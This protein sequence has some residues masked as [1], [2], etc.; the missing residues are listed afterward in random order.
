MIRAMAKPKP[1]QSLSPAQ[2]GKARVLLNNAVKFMQAGMG[3]QARAHC[4]QVLAFAPDHAQAHYLLGL[5]AIRAGRFEEARG[6]IDRSL[7]LE[8]AHPAG[9]NN[10]GVVLKKLGLP[11]EALAHFEAAAAQ[12]PDY[13]EAH[14]NHGNTSME[15]GDAAAAVASFGRAIAARPGYAEAF[16]NQAHALAAMGRAAEALRAVDDSLALK[17][18][19]ASAHTNRGNILAGLRRFDDALAAFGRATQLDPADPAPLANRGGVL[20]ELKRHDEAIEDLDRAIA[21]DPGHADAYENRANAAA[22]AKRRLESV[23]YFERLYALAPD[24]PF[25]PGNL[26][27]AKMLCSDWDG[28][29]ALSAVIREGLQARRPVVEPFGYQGIAADEADLLACAEIFAAREF[30][31]VAAP[32]AEDAVS[33]PGEIITIGYLCGEFRQHATSILLCGVYEAHDRSRFRLVALDNGIGDTQGGDDYRRRIEAAFDTI[34]DI[35]H[36]GDDEAA[37]RIAQEKIDILVNLNGYFG[38]GRLGVFARRPAR[39]QVNYLGFPGTIGAPYIDYLI[40]DETVIPAAS[41]AHYTEKVVWLPHSYQANDDRRAI[42]TQAPTRGEQ[43]LPAQA[44]VYCCFNN[45][46]KITPGTFGVWMRILQRTPG[47]CLWLLEDDAVVAANLRREATARGVDGARLVFSARLAPAEH[48]ARHRLAD[49][50]LDTL[51][52]NA[53]T[54]A[55]DALWAGL[56]VLAQTGNTFPGRVTTSLLRALGLDDLAVATAQAYEDLAVHLATD[57]Q[58]LSGVRAR[59]HAART[60]APLFD[61]TRFTR[62]LEAAYVEMVRRDRAGEAPGHFSIPAGAEPG[63]A[64]PGTA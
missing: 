48:L 14:H 18:D 42:A 40:A 43:G 60:E 12:K 58:A 50:F 23:A 30:P 53:H 3:W 32:A 54:T 59:L 19:N 16:N 7:Q 46:Y 63:N 24:Y 8:P 21:L 35:S 52:Y 38:D 47:S 27:H 33:A 6:S 2:Q 28:I 17:P 39:V 22:G 56:P 25:V 10:L 34:V 31:Q 1:S 4:E 44:F 51:P 64:S 26:L 37:Q 55:S 29:E 13:A 36:L 5:V 61:T 9:H 11:R 49:L 45:N 41:R 20:M 62:H 15:L 57:A